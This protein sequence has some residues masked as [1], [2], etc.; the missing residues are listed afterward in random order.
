MKVE[1]VSVTHTNEGIRVNW[2]DSTS[3]VFSNPIYLAESFV[4]SERRM[5]EARRQL[6]TEIAKKINE[7][8]KTMTESPNEPEPLCIRELRDDITEIARLLA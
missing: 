5:A 4:R 6:V 7:I 8:A 1:V 2:P 3:S